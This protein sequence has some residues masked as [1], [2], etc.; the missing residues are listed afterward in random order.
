MYS[1][2]LDD[3]YSKDD[4]NSLVEEINM[5]LHESGSLEGGEEIKSKLSGKVRNSLFTKIS[6][7][8]IDSDFLGGLKNS[9]LNLKEV[10][11]TF[12]KEL[13]VELMEKVVAKI[14][15]GSKK[16]VVIDSFVDSSLIGG[17]TISAGGKYKDY[18][19]K[20]KLHGEK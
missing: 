10:K 8:G 19:V 17:I 3:I 9:L 1:N 11:I 15:E 7:S 18:S 2:F 12:A 20:R 13:G 6:D 14:N 4:V 16:K 5:I